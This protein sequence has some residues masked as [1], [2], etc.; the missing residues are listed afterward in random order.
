M[1]ELLK[2]LSDKSKRE[3]IKKTTLEG[4][5]NDPSPIAMW[6]WHNYTILTSKKH[7]QLNEKNMIDPIEEQKRDGFEILIENYL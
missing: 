5:P 2:A 1:N 7:P 3:Q 4:R 6:G